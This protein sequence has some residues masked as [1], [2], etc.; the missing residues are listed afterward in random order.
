MYKLISAPIQGCDRNLIRYIYSQRI[1]VTILIY[2]NKQF[3]IIFILLKKSTREI[4]FSAYLQIQKYYAQ[5]KNFHRHSPTFSQPSFPR[6]YTRKSLAKRLKHTVERKVTNTFMQ[7]P[8]YLAESSQPSFIV[9][10]QRCCLR[11]TEIK[12]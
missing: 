5:Y 9:V 8:T 1:D 11:P 6:E 10:V 3:L 2:I 12:Q 7:L 4:F